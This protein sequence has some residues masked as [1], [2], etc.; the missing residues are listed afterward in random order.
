MPRMSK[1]ILKAIKSHLSVIET[2]L[3]TV[4]IAN[5]AS[6]KGLNNVFGIE[7]VSKVGYNSTRDV[8]ENSTLC[9]TV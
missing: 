5:L 4:I 2:V 1:V 6:V 3:S 8:E 7:F 9:P